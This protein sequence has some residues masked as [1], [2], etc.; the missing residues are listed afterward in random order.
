MFYLNAWACADTGCAID[1]SQLAAGSF[2]V[3]DA[4]NSILPDGW[5]LF[6]AHKNKISS[7]YPMNGRV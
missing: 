5:M 2:I 6:A 3:V 4:A 7:G 1:A